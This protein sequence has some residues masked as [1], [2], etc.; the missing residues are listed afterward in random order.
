MKRQSSNFYI[1]A[2]DPSLTAWGWAIINDSGRVVETGAIRTEYRAKKMSIREGDDR[3]RRINELTSKLLRILEKYD[4]AL[5]LSE[6]PHGSQS[7]S[8][9]FMIGV[10]TGV[11]QTIGNCMNISV[12]W[13][14]E[15]D[16]KRAVGGKR[17]LS[18]EGMI[19]KIREI[20]PEVQWTGVK[21]EN[22]AIADAVAIY[23]LATRQSEMLKFIKS[24]R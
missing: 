6:L 17:N 7:S 12:E 24:K 20:Y 1:M 13:F 11:A 18:K 23:H 8:A 4:V 9:A 15:S 22:E 5:I 14:G 19:D 2:N 10:V 3:V 16:A 21:K